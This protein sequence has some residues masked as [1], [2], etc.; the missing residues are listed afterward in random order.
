MIR[1]LLISILLTF[2]VKNYSQQL[3]FPC[4]IGAGAYTTGG[5]GGKICHVDTLAWNTSITYD[6]ITDSYSGGFYNMF[7]ELDIPAKQIV[8]TIGG[9]IEVPTYTILDFSTK[10]HKGNITVS[11]Q[12]SPS[13][14]VFKTG[15]FLVEDIE[16][17]IFR[18]LSFYND[19]ARVPG[20]D[21]FSIQS[22]PEVDGGVYYTHT[23]QNIIVDHCSFYYGGDECLSIS[24]RSSTVGTNGI[25][26][27]NPITNVT[28][29]NSIMA[30][31]SKGSI[32]GSYTGNTQNTMARCGF[33]ETAYRF[34]NLVAAGNSQADAIN[35][36]V[37]DYSS[38]LIRTT[39]DGNFNVQNFLMVP[40][41]RD[42]GKHRVQIADSTN[43]PKIYSG[44]HIIVGVKDSATY[45]DFDL[46][47]TFAGSIGGADLPMPNY[48]KHNTPF[49]LVGEPF[50]IYDASSLRT[51]VVP[52][53]GNDKRLDQ[54]GTIIN[55]EYAL[56]SFYR[57]LMLNFSPNVANF[58]RYPVNKYPN[59]QQGTPYVSSLKDGIPD[60]WRANNMNG[61]NHYDIAP[62]GYTWLEEFLNQV[63][64]VCDTGYV[65]N[66]CSGKNPP[67]ATIASPLSGNY[68]KADTINLAISYTSDTTVT[69]VTYYLNGNILASTTNPFT[70]NTTGLSQG[71]HQIHAVLQDLCGNSSNTDTVSITITP[72]Q[73][74]VCKTTS[75]PVIDGLEDAIWNNA[76]YEKMGVS[77]NGLPYPDTN[78]LKAS[79]KMMWDATGLYFFIKVKDDTLVSDSPQLD[80]FRDD[81]ASIYIDLSDNNSITYDADDYFFG[82]RRGSTDINING[83]LYLGT[84]VTKADIVTTEGYDMEI[85]I[86][87]TYF[88][89]F[90]PDTANPIGLDFRVDD[91]DNGGSREHHLLW[92]DE[93]STLWAD[94]SKL[95]VLKLNDYSCFNTT[96]VIKENKDDIIVYP[97]PTNGEVTIKSENVIT[98]VEVYNSL[99]ASVLSKGNINTKTA[100]FSLSNLS[101][102]I[103]TVKVFN[104]NSVIEKQ[105]IK[106]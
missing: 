86:N 23:V 31:S 89:A 9:T 64:A 45:P 37:E 21:A 20:A 100:T 35:N 24:G 3:A 43:P 87:W 62:S 76:D 51:T 95:G 12:T 59:P 15:Y 11:G 66:N 67:V 49:P 8:F 78:T 82:F 104:P 25:G 55:H 38:R 105:I 73:I 70:F 68:N 91:D 22:K 96:K 83:S 77:E 69:S 5:R 41:P 17:V 32:L 48:A 94:P 97:N 98:K 81:A 50:Q 16:N 84:D 34:P 80:F 54:N 88:G 19:G 93:T 102:G 44:G 2:A 74:G 7:Y 29:Q 72:L 27:G 14:I 103:Y 1:L 58:T 26:A 6:P 40:N 60:T 63:D 75:Q 4:A 85:K 71:T 90:V 52:F 10:T 57:D 13:K 56:D 53:I 65:T 99:G 79:Y 30:A 47:L 61:E 101:K 42:Y 28:V 36:Y 39:G 106:Q 92:N 33:I 46:W 18:Y